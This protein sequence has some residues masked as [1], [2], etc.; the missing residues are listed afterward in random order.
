ML[1][2]YHFVLVLQ[3]DGEAWSTGRLDWDEEGI[4]FSRLPQPVGWWAPVWHLPETWGMKS[5]A[6][7]GGGILGGQ[8]PGAASP[9]RT[10]CSNLGLW[11]HRETWVPPSSTWWAA[12]AKYSPV[13]IIGPLG[14][15]SATLAH[16]P[17]FRF[18]LGILYEYCSTPVLPLFCTWLP[19]WPR[20]KG[21][22]LFL[23]PIEVE[24]FEFF[25]FF[26]Q[27][28]WLHIANNVTDWICF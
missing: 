18:L 5:R 7:Q 13:G 1:K 8:T 19:Y 9:T 23:S 15:G 22:N 14:H 2:K 11:Q 17:M 21:G 25:F 6:R 27:V 20:A 4:S 24:F 3:T 10:G 26:F 16:H 28:H 12:F